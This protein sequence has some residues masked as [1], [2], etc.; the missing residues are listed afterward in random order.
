MNNVSN[1]RRLLAGLL[2]IIM[3]SSVPA[4]FADNEVVFRGSGN[5]AT[6]RQAE[7]C[8]DVDLTFA[9]DTT[10]SMTPALDN[11][12][13]NLPAIIATADLR[14]DDGQARIGVIHFDGFIDPP[15]P[16]ADYV[17]VL[18]DL[19]APRATAIANI[20]GLAIG[21][22]GFT[23]E[24]AG[25]AKQA[26]LLN[27]AAGS[28][29]DADGV[30]GN[31]FGSFTAPWTADQKILILVT[32]APNGG[33]NDANS[34]A[35]D[36][37]MGDLGT[38]A[39]G[40]GIKLG[41]VL[42]LGFEDPAIA[43]PM[44]AEAANSGGLYGFTANGVDTAQVIIDII[45][46]LPCPPPVGGDMLPIDSTALFVAGAGANAFWILPL[47]GGVVGAGFFVAR[48]KFQRMD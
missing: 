25:P 14:D 37:Q 30:N 15:D 1:S 46:E 27:R 48:N 36:A 6:I 33:F 45:A 9:I 21:F 31:Q 20:N 29:A 19:S 23:P 26:A 42:V 35:D 4:A 40:L 12:K 44:M 32:D 18:N 11:V 5:T 2:A 43:A 24:A 13:A 22:G 34:A 3:M 16:D 41:D 10:G 7:I 47:L 8:G 28:Y 17:E 39:A 38:L